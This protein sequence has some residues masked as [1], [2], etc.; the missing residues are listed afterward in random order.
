M[1]FFTENFFSEEQKAELLGG[2]YAL[3]QRGARQSEQEVRSRAIEIAQTK[4]RLQRQ[5]DE[6]DKETKL[7]ELAVLPLI[8]T[9]TLAFGLVSSFL[10]DVSI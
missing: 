6:F 4:E 7:V 9:I 1:R 5:Q 2:K 3:E 8:L 10:L